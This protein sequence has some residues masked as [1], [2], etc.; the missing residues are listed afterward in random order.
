M[1]I[2]QKLLDQIRYNAVAINL[3][4]PLHTETVILYNRSYKFSHDHIVT[5]TRVSQARANL[6]A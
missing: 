6:V 5:L 2:L 4:M 3:S 1:H